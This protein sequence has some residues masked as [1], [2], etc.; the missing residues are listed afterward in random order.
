[1]EHRAGSLRRQDPCAAWK[2]PGWKSASAVNGAY[3]Y[4]GSLMAVAVRVE[5]CLT[6]ARA[7]GR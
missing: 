6:R 5:R 4:P 7:G 2:D 1:M 3:A